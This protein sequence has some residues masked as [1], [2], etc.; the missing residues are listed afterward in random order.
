MPIP[1][2]G[3]WRRQ[4]QAELLALLRPL[5]TGYGTL[6]QAAFAATVLYEPVNTTGRPQRLRKYEFCMP[7][8]LDCGAG[9]LNPT[10]T[11]TGRVYGEEVT[12]KFSA[13]GWELGEVHMHVAD[14]LTPVAPSAD[15]LAMLADI[16]TCVFESFWI[17]RFGDR[18]V[19]DG[20]PYVTAT[21]H[22]WLDTDF[23]KVAAKKLYD[24]KLL[25]RVWL[26]GTS[27]YAYRWSNA[28]R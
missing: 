24:A 15:A 16:P 8:E 11:L 12:A 13:E 2:K 21:T 7:V 20:P 25:E 1:T 6:S 22:E 19:C 18:W 27:N 28:D 10:A 4:S 17:Q 3:G 14:I 26:A 5:L 9:Q 23:Y